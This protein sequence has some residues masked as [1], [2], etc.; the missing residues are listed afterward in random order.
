MITNNE[1]QK[2]L[3]GSLVAK[4]LAVTFTERPQLDICFIYLN[5]V[6]GSIGVRMYYKTVHTMDQ[7]KYFGKLTW[8]QIL[9]E[10]EKKN[11]LLFG[12]RV[13]HYVNMEK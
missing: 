5:E 12:P 13:N 3:A 2:V 4:P 6:N 9:V 7:W 1:K 11:P 10:A 8:D